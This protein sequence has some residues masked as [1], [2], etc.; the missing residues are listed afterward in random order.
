MA[1][2]TSRVKSQRAALEPRRRPGKERVA[3]LME[4]AASVIAE[5]GYEAATMAE[6]AARAGALVGSLYHFFPSKEALAEALI[7]R[8]E[9][10]VDDAFARID[11]RA[12]SMSVEELAN[13]LIGLMIGI[14]VESRAMVA[15]LEARADWSAKRREFMDNSLRRIAKTLTL[16]SPALDAESALSIA[17]VLLQ[18]MKAM[19]ALVAEYGEAS[20]AVAE[21]REMT[22]VYLA[23]KFR[24]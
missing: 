19:K 8:Y 24:G 1:S 20:G 2:N 12:A 14:Q 7:R 15:L 23:N 13:A 10:I 17:V 21:L 4:A 6:I 5:K 3:A 18:N 11:E 9:G 22:Q 16:K